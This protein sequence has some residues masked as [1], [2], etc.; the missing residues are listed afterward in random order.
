M[1]TRVLIANRGAIAVRIIRTLK[2][3]G[4][5]AIAVYHEAD[6]QSLHV[7]R[8]DTAISLGAGSAADTYLNIDKI[9]RAAA[10]SGAQAVHPGYG[11]LSENTDFVA[12]CESAGLHF[13]GP[14]A[15]QITLF[16]LKHEARAAAERAA[17]PL[18]PGSP[19]LT[20]IE[21]ALDRAAQI[22]FP[23]MLKSTAGGGGIG[24]Q[25][26]HSTADLRSAWDSV[27]RLGANYFAND[28]VFL[29]KYIARAR[30][31]EVQV[32]GDGAGNTVS[33]G[34]RDCS[35]QRRNQKVIEETPAPNL[36]AP[37]RRRLHTTAERLMASVD[38][39]NA[40]TVEFIYDTDAGAFYFLEVNTRLQVEH[41]ITEAVWSVDLVEWMLKQA[42]GELG[43]LQQRKHQLEPG[44]HAIQARLYAED[45]NREFQPCA[46]LLTEVHWP[47][48]AGLRIDHW[49]EAGL[50]VPALFDP[51]LA[52]V[53]VCAADRETAREQ[54]DRHLAAST[55]YGIET[56]LDY[57]RAVLNT[58]PFRQGR[59][60]TASLADFTFTPH[61]LD[62]LQS[63]T[64]T[65][66]QDYPGR[67]DL[68]HI[69]VPP[70]GPMDTLNFRL[71]NK[72]VDNPETAAGLEITLHGPTLSFNRPC[73]IAL[74]GATIEAS[75]DGA[76]VA[77][78]QTLE[79]PAKAVLRLG[80]ITGKGARA[81]LALAGGI[82]CPD[83]LGSKSTF[84]LGQFGGHGGRALRSG[85]VLHLGGNTSEVLSG[86]F[87][88]ET[89]TS[90]TFTSETVTP[91]TVTSRALTSEP[92][93][94]TLTGSPAKTFAETP[95]N[96][97]ASTPPAS[98]APEHRPALPEVWELRVIYG[99]HGAPDFFSDR[100]IEQFFSH[101]WE[102]HYNSSRTGVRLIGPKPQWARDSGG[103]AGLH[104]SN[105]HDN[106]YA[107]GTVDFTGDMP[108][109]LG[110]DGPSLGGFVCPATVVQADLWKLGQL[111]AGAKLKF[112]PVTHAW[113]TALEAAQTAAIA[114]LRA[115][116]TAVAATASLPSPIAGRARLGDD[117]VVYRLAGDHFLLLE[118]GPLELNIERRFRVHA[119]MLWLQD[120]TL[121]GIREL[122][123]GIRSLQIH[124]D[125]QQLDLQKL[126]AHLD[127][128][129]AAVAQNPD[130]S[131]PAR[132]VHLPL[133]WDDE[134]CQQ[135]V[136][137]YM[138][139]V[140]Q[141]APWC[142]SNLEFI[143]RIN[144][145]P[146]I[147]AVKEIVF[148]AAYLVLGLGD[149]YLGA[150]VA[151]PLDPRH[152]LVTT[153][154][155][156]ART[157]TAEN[158]VGIGGAYLCV[159][160]MEGPGGYQFV[161][162]TLQMWNRYR[163]TEVFEKPWLLRFFDQI[164]FYEVS[165]GELAQIRRDF[166]LGNYPLKI[167]HTRFDLADYQRF[168]DANAGAIEQFQQR[169]QTAFDAEL[170]RWRA[171]GQ[172]TYEPQVQ[173]PTEDSQPPL[174]AG[175]N[176]IDSPVSGSVW[177]LKVAA[178]QQVREGDTLMALESMKMEI[179]INADRS[180]KVVKVLKDQGQAVTAGETLLWVEES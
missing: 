98:I 71:A 28:G 115:D 33:L 9:L 6:A 174:P 169:R 1:F 4:I 20:D 2:K 154:Y 46:G 161:G 30:H 89:F 119:L 135:A 78:Y 121:T 167:E 134:A 166:P 101:T 151:T 72:L 66:I 164:R 124:Y 158:S 126:L 68:W 104:P 176:G 85:D 63:G 152:R 111:K 95:T 131:V 7:R 82:Q 31:I 127:T 23:V 91:E 64:Q 19:L 100:D 136:D 84:T 145:L 39:R 56:N 26:C 146:D 113:A 103:E 147:A 54:L 81:Y 90:G 55:L 178:G 93:T 168:L 77:M 47:A 73:R 5:H 179:E 171:G 105:I 133:S 86:T 132:I 94:K 29:E 44:G 18:V 53:I 142:P 42:A 35:A 21:D 10:Q 173:S 57:V 49:I 38:Y 16:G 128:A 160:G 140:R 159:Y 144:G 79:V 155:N 61:T 102:V 114:Q 88:S 32:F 76:P 34:E 59:L 122:T 163:Q 45:P 99:P 125:P 22:G 138:Q 70:S 14:S 67:T 139:T 37:L 130:S 36:P 170:S 137:R 96:A 143:R 25:V 51:M 165:A 58:E 50:E 112:T 108:V 141:D 75:I 107:F 117:E 69:G 12:R 13:I 87:T 180:G 40:G 150:P 27:R 106:A 148:N 24:M 123:P 177:Q 109:I 52:K 65:T 118:L 149:V 120:H 110:P 157:W 116:T 129:V 15:E 175:T 162:R 97:K 80:A 83:Y 60:H 8:A 17:V 172:L 41:G 153:K 11:F 74:T 92:S 62:V 156:P 43:D 3:L 48:A